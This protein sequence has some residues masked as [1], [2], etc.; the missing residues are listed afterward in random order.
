VMLAAIAQ[1]DASSRPMRFAGI[2]GCGFVALAI[3]VGLEPRCLGGP[4]AMIDPVVRPIW[5]AEVQEME[6]L[7]RLLA[8]SPVA[9][10]WIA[11]FP[12]FALGCAGWL[13]SDAE[14]RRDSA[15]LTAV[16]S[17]VVAIALMVS[18]VKAYSYAMWFAM[19]VVAAA[20]SLFFA[21][22]EIRRPLRWMSALVVTP[23][24]ISAGAI[25]FARANAPAPAK[26][27][28]CFKIAPYAALSELPAGL[29]AA[30]VDLGPSL[31]AFT[32]HAVLAAPYHRISQGIVTVHRALSSAPEEARKILAD[33]HADYLV[34]CGA[35]KPMTLDGA[36]LRDALWAKLAANE[37]PA[38][39]ER[40]QMPQGNPF[41]VYRVKP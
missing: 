7:A 26:L 28:A 37:V 39:L 40:V 21:R 11:A 32:H 1:A 12:G 15:T 30:D 20:A 29:I 19:P 4:F 9:G 38:W 16:A 23:V 6:P 5:L 18:V 24:M 13:L 31:L 33:A 8:S 41:V 27:D 35:A 36:A 17:L 10:I 3:Y 2:A 22:F 14:A 25:S 34:L